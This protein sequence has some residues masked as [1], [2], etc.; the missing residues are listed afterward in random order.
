[1]VG[2]TQKQRA[3]DKTKIEIAKDINTVIFTAQNS[4]I[5]ELLYYLY[6]LHIVRL[7]NVMFDVPAAEKN[8]TAL[9]VRQL[10]DAYTYIIQLLYKYCQVELIPSDNNDGVINQGLTTFL[11]K[12]VLHINAKYETLSIISL[13]EHV[14]V[15]GERDQF[16]KLDF[17]L[18]KQDEYVNKYF[19]YAIRADRA[20]D[21]L[22]ETFITKDDYLKHF[23][24][25]YLPYADLFVR[26]FGVSL[27]DFI[28]II[29]YLLTSVSFKIQ[30][31]EGKL[32]RLSNGL[33]DVR[34]YQTLLMVSQLM[35]MDQ[36][37]VI[38]KFGI[39]ALCIIDRLT[40]KS[41]ELDEHQLKYNLVTR[42]PLLKIDNHLFVSPELLLDSLLINTHYSLLEAGNL[43]EEY[44]KRYSSVF[45]NKILQIVAKYGYTEVTRGLELFERKN[46]LGDIDLVLKN[47]DNRY[48]LV[49]AKN[50]TIP[51]DVY[52]HDFEATKKHLE[53]L[54][55][56]WEAKVNK[57]AIHLNLNHAKYG[58]PA[59]YSYIVVSKS[60]EIL[61]HFSSYL[62]LSI[63][64]F[65]YWIDQ[66]DETL[67]FNKLVEDF[68]KLK[69]HE[70]TEDQLHQIHQDLNTGWKF[71]S[72]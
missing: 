7:T 29:D 71:E 21:K 65:A 25:D 47:K 41:D 36:Q 24:E 42:Q 54:Q 55:V 46:Q 26:E 50:H 2:K 6:F 59:D 70:F 32:P 56:E 57:R 9:C 63:D 43:K 62:I 28:E 30:C 51:M 44:K 53:Y 11:T 33:V 16:V 52:F 5:G 58:I 18:I 66:K 34:S 38:N 69:N 45:L 19:H 48:L 17:S 39:K 40:L 37:E 67:T 27:D 64:E 12:A 10:T 8:Y 35:I 3:I 68:Y 61:S 60:P 15:S 4:G 1:M 13:F 22:K 20:N 72:K 31:I 14:E 49:E 23:H